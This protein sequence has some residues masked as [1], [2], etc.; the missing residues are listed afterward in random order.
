MLTFIL[1]IINLFGFNAPFWFFGISLFID[2]GHI[3]LAD[4]EILK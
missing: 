4:K 2:I 3:G 1:F